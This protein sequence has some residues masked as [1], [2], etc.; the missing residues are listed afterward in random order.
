MIV[1]AIV[2]TLL[3]VAVPTFLGSRSSGQ[4][5]AA[6]RS[7]RTALTAA[8]AA[9]TAH[10]SFA[11]AGAAALAGS[12]FSLHYAAGKIVSTAPTSVS[13]T[14]EADG[15]SAAAQSESGTC[16]FIAATPGGRVFYG[17]ASD[18]PCSGDGARNGARRNTW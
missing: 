9:F 3:S 4:D 15:W 18:G 16:Y 14:N 1:V 6:Q 10:R 12:N 5:A 2:G 7:L 8:D 13:V 11:D 17:T